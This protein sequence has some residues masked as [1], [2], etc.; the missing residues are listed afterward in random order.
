MDNTVA[1][2]IRRRFSCRRHPEQA[3]TAET[4]EQLQAFL[5]ELHTG[6]FGSHSRFMLLAATEEGRDALKG[7]GTYGVIRHA[8]GFIVGAVG[9]GDRNLEDYGYL[10]ERAVLFATGLDLGTC[11]LGGSFSKSAFAHRCVATAA[12]AVPA[13]VSVGYI[14]DR[15]KAEDRIRRR[16]QG[17]LRLPA[18]Q[19]FFD[20]RFGNP[21]ERPVADAFSTVLEMVRLA[22]SASNKQPWRII[23]AGD[24]WHFYLHRTPGYGKDSMIGRLIGVAD[25]QRLDMGIAM[26]HFEFTAREMGLN[27]H[28][29]LAEPQIAKP[30]P[31]VEYS[32]TWKSGT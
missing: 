12:E 15:A 27:G 5:K 8:A 9:P 22:P 23:R 26:C 14:A 30:G 28:W 11:W 2:Q 31:E 6:P 25:V 29:T 24:S 7:V 20:E 4:R 13:V 3:I 18:E 1:E 16:D 10:M 17:G 21:L 19:L 32:A